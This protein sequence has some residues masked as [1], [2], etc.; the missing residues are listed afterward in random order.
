MGDLEAFKSRRDMARQAEVA[1]KRGEM[2]DRFRALAD[3]IEKGEVTGY[4]LVTIDASGQA[5][6]TEW[7]GFCSAA[8]LGHGLSCLFHR[9]FRKHTS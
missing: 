2:A 4:A 3:Q 7:L 6:L 5:P 8:A 1:R 9:F